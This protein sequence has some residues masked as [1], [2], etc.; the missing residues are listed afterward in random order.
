VKRFL[1]L[2][3]AGG[4]LA[5]LLWLFSSRDPQRPAPDLR[6]SPLSKQPALPAV[7]ARRPSLLATPESFKEA[8]RIQ[9]A[10]QPDAFEAFENWATQFLAG[11]NSVSTPLGV[12]LAWKRRE[13]MLELIQRDPKK[14]LDQTVPFEWRTALPPEVTR[15]FETLIDGRG[16]FAVTIA[17]DFERGKVAVR[18]EA[19]I[20]GHRYEAFVYGRRLSQGTKNQ[21]PLHGIAVEDKLALHV[22]PVRI[23][24]RAEA[25]ARP[26]AADQQA[27]AICGVSGQPV[28]VRNSPTAADTG[29]EIRYFCGVDH[30]QMVN[31]N[32]IAAEQNATGEMGTY[33]ANGGSDWTHGPKTVLYIRVNFP[34]DLTE[35]ISEAQAYNA[36]NGVNAYYTEISYDMTALTATVT[37]LLTLPKTKAWYRTSGPG[38]PRSCP[39]SRLRDWQLRAGHRQFHLHRRVRFRGVGVRRGQRGLAAKHRGGSDQP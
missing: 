38:C 37:P 19:Q 15:Y 8:A 9:A 39:K 29:G 18:R 26:L 6:P 1:L 27:E 34:D 36:M 13:A 25:K 28:E 11:T 24:T 4:A 23:L 32:W 35:P 2:C 7:Q 17:T 3:G 21:L 20:D 22:D 16:A 30:A 12:G 10:V 31:Q 14:A 5:L 33:A